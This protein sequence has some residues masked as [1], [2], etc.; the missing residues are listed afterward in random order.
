MSEN[1]IATVPPGGVLEAQVQAL[2]QLLEQ[3]RQERCAQLQ[4]EAMTKAGALVRQAHRAARQRMGEAVQAER[5]RARQQLAASRAQVQTRLRQQQ[6]QTAHLM[7]RHGWE[8]L[9]T[10]VLQR[11]KNAPAR[12]QWVSGLLHQALHALPRCHWV[13]EHPPGWESVE[14]E[15]LLPALQGHCGALPRFRADANLHAGL[16]ICAEGA[17]LDGTLEGLLADRNAIEADLLAQLQRLLS[18]AGA[19]TP[20]EGATP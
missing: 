7:L 17:C 11:W 16:R 12:R 13:I 14:C 18:S 2:L 5:L 15:S 3:Y 1:G 8:L 6:Y 19:D 9:G 10:A 4:A 20:A